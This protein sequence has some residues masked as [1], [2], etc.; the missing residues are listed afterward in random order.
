[1]A[2]AMQEMI[3]AE[4]RKY[5]SGVGIPAGCGAGAVGEACIPLLVEGVMRAAAERVGVVT[6]Q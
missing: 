1:M 6:R 4:V 3:R 5:M 2:A